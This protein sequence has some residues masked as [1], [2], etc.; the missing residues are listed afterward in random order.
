MGSR[1]GKHFVDCIHYNLIVSYRLLG[2]YCDC[3]LFTDEE[4]EAQ[5]VKWLAQGHTVQWQQRGRQ[6]E[7]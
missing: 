3:S 1:R 2:K 6:Q 5:E 7:G 4:T